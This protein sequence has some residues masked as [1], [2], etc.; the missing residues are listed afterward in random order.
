MIGL[1]LGI[2]GLV[3]LTGGKKKEEVTNAPAHNHGH[4]HV[5]HS[6]SEMPSV[7]SPAFDKWLSTPGNFEKIFG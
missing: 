5:A 1:Y 7:D 6:G 2:Y 3:K 4:S